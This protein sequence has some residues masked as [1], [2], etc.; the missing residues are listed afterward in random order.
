MACSS[1]KAID[2]IFWPTLY[3]A[4]VRQFPLCAKGC[5][6]MQADWSLAD[7]W[8]RNRSILQAIVKTIL[9]DHSVVD[10]VLQDA[11]IQ[12]IA[13]EPE[14][15]D[16]QEA[17]NYARRAVINTAINHYRRSRRNLALVHALKEQQNER[18]ER[19]PLAMMMESEQAQTLSAVM[20][21]LGPALSRLSPDRRQALELVFN[22]NDKLKEI[23]RETGIPYTTLRSRVLSAVDQIRKHLRVRR[24]LPKDEGVP[25]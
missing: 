11:F 1:V 13:A 21:E 4:R 17:Y 6:W 3:F 2:T 12:V 14:L 18:D 23:C 9:L 8:E 22:R 24:L 5:G 19:T 16:E 10:D 25:K 7:I 15:E 20:R